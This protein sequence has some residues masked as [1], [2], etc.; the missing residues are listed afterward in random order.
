MSEKE[1]RAIFKD[2]VT[3]QMEQGPISGD[4]LSVS[5]AGET[6]R[7]NQANKSISKKL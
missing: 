1:E 7:C 6:Y 2:M 4:I 3:A 5:E